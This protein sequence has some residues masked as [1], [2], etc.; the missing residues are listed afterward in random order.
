MA[1]EKGSFSASFSA[2]L[3]FSLP[4]SYC[5]CLSLPWLEGKPCFCLPSLPPSP[6]SPGWQ[7][8]ALHMGL[9]TIANAI[10][11]VI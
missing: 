3:C 11:I 6:N 7:G 8:L 4:H 1:K 10:R 9:V 2:P 5:L